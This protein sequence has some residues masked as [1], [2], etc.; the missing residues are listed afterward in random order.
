M[1]SLQHL[2]LYGNAF[3]GG[4]SSCF[5]KISNLKSL[6]VS[7]CSL[8]VQLSQIMKYLS[9]MTD[10][11]EYLNLE[12]NYIGSSLPDVLANFSSLRELRLGFN[13]LNGSIPRAVGKLPRLALLD[14]SSNEIVGSIPD[15]LPLSSLRELD[16]SHNQLS[17]LT[18]SMDAFPNLRSY[19]SILTISSDWIPPFQLD[20][21][22]LTHCKL[23]PHFPNWLR[24]Q[25]NIFVLDLSAAGILGNIPSSQRMIY[26]EPKNAL[27]GAKDALLGA[28]DALLGAKNVEEN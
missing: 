10:S 6:Q 14:L 16:L 11:L 12:R 3:G 15:L 4:F 1:K 26:L 5:G 28:K 9:C 23:G 20:I 24:D 27:L 17:G 21:I 19:T 8:H 7:F 22:R 25:N 18:E 13:E 2:D